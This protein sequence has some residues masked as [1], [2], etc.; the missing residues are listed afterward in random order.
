LFFGRRIF[1]AQKYRRS[2]GWRSTAV[3]IMFE[4]K[5]GAHLMPH[6]SECWMYCF[7]CLF[8]ITAWR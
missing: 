6:D 3:Y 5:V 7:N 2:F 4:S 8:K 1:C